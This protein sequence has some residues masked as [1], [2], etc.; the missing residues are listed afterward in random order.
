[1]LMLSCSLATNCNEFT[2]SFSDKGSEYTFIKIIFHHLS[3]LIIENFCKVE[4]ENARVYEPPL[5]R[6]IH[7]R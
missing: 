4:C 5:D 1:M 6:I 7:T 3:E 2:K